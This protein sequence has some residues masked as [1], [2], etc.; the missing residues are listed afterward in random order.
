MNSILR[1]T[2]MT[3]GTIIIHP[4]G[5]KAVKT[6]GTNAIPETR[7]TPEDLAMIMIIDIVGTSL[8]GKAVM[9]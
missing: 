1:E 4:R 6:P 5:G 9:K 8:P 2:S 7:G 3:G